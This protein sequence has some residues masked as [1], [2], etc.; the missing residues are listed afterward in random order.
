MIEKI[1]VPIDGSSHSIRAA[2]F[3]SD[4]AAKYDAEII[5]LHVLLRG[6]M[7]EGL[8]RAMEVEVR[9]GNSATADNLVNYP[10]SIMA[11]VDDKSATQL[12][13]DELNFIGKMMLSGVTELCREKGVKNIT[14]NINEGNTV[15]LIIDL[16][17]SSKVDLIVM[18]SRGLSQLTGMLMGSV[19]HKVNYLSPC[20]C[21]TVK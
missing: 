16:A 3:A 20:A 1:L 5:L 12:S 4:L 18:G 19:S 8:K 6:H 15:E 17:T 21:L 11:R 14:Q 10:Q 2:E 13:L 9:R 7:P